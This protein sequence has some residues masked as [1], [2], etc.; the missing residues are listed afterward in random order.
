V[1]AKVFFNAGD[2]LDRQKSRGDGGLLALARYISRSVDR[3]IN[4]ANNL[5]FRA[6]GKPYALPTKAEVVVAH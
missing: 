6:E 4:F 5:R 2:I 1:A 3:T